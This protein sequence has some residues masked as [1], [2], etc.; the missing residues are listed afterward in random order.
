MTNNTQK[1]ICLCCYVALAFCGVYTVFMAL[2][3]IQLLNGKNDIDWLQNGIVKL[4]FFSLY[5]ISSFLMMGMWIKV[6]LNILKGLRES[7][8][9]PKNNVHLLFWLALV[10]FI[11]ILC[12]SN[13]MILYHDEFAFRVQ[14]NN[15]IMPFFLL[16]FAFMYKV[17]AD[18]VEENNLTI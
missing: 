3:F 8:V 11:Y 14:A 18:A 6:V 17:A 15:L 1:K 13:Q 12:W 5:V 16:F 7:V 9:F 10:Y 4:S 2:H